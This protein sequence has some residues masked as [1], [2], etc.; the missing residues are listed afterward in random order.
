MT[1]H[2]TIAQTSSLRAFV[3]AIGFSADDLGRL[4]LQRALRLNEHTLV[5]PETEIPAG[6]RLTIAPHYTVKYEQQGILVVNKSAGLPSQ[7]TRSK[8]DNLYERLSSGWDYIGLH[9]RLDK[10]ASGLMLL[11]TDRRCNKAIGR[12][13]A[14]HKITRKYLAIVLGQ[15]D[16]AGQWNTTIAGKHAR[17]HFRCISSN[18]DTSTLLLTLETGR[19]HQ[20]RRHASQAGYPLIGD[21]RYG[22]AAAMLCSRL[23]LH[24]VQLQ[25]THPLNNTTVRCDSAIPHALQTEVS[26]E[27]S[28]EWLE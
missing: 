21:R 1:E 11:T 26:L 14:E 16:T 3:A 2:I 22:G 28:S 15:P 13:F 25:F 17:T 20:I 6:Q 27:D 4:L 5:D 8:Q 19:T 7:P 23:A 9:H 12:A 18:G 24:A 10:E